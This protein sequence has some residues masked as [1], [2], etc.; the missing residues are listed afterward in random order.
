PLLVHPPYVRFS[1]YAIGQKEVIFF[2]RIKDFELRGNYGESEILFKNDSIFIKPDAF[3]HGCFNAK[4]REHSPMVND[5]QMDGFPFHDFAEAIIEINKKYDQFRKLVL[6]EEAVKNEK[7][8]HEGYSNKT[9]SVPGIT[10]KQL[11]GFGSKS[12]FHEYL[13]DLLIDEVL[14]TNQ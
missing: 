1:A 12:K 5:I 8:E 4:Y 14:T 10:N 9:G 11:N 13:L 6:N 2:R 7:D 3:R